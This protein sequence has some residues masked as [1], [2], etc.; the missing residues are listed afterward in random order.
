MPGETTHTGSFAAVNGRS[1][2]TGHRVARLFASLIPASVLI[3]VALVQQYYAHQRDLTPWK[4][5]GFGM[6][7]T[8]DSR[9]ARFVKVWLM[10]EG[11][12]YR[13][14]GRDVV[15]DFDLGGRISDIR[16]IPT[17]AAVDDLAQRLARVDWAA[18]G[19]PPPPKSVNEAGNAPSPDAPPLKDRTDVPSPPGKVVAVRVDVWRYHFDPQQQSIVASVAVTSTTQVDQP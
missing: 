5:G 9:S 18:I 12:P 10:T 17:P 16:S 15:P 19:L 1:D 2:A 14:R 8:V 7:S 6:F 4:G 13:L 11:E 3:V